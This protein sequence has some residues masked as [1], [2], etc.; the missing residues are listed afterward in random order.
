MLFFCAGQTFIKNLFLKSLYSGIICYTEQ[1]KLSKFI[2]QMS[3]IN[4][5][6]DG[7]ADE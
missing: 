2:E 3:M 4:M 7:H 6:S 1:E 5:E